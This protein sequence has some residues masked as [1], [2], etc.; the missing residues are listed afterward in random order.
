[1]LGKSPLVRCTPLKSGKRKKRRPQLAEALR[2]IAERS[3]GRCIRCGRRCDARRDRHHVLPVS[4]FPEHETE[5]MNQVL[6]CL[7]CHMD[8]ESWANRLRYD[9][10]PGEVVVWVRTLG[11]REALE[12][13]RSYPTY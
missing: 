3:Q 6:A 1:M 13:E 10:L 12:L 9:E 7:Q 5:P 8:H 4:R 2:A 11:G